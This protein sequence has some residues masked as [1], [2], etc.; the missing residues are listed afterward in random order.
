MFGVWATLLIHVNYFAFAGCVY[1]TLTYLRASTHIEEAP[2]A[3]SYFALE[4]KAF[5][6]E[7]F[8]MECFV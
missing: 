4:A 6:F 8:E 2:A 3:L 1:R 7:I 5:A